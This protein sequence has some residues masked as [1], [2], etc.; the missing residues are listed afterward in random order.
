MRMRKVQMPKLFKMLLRFSTNEVLPR[1]VLQTTPQIHLPIAQRIKQ[2]SQLVP[3]SGI[4]LV[5]IR[6]DV[7]TGIY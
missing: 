3:V 5:K 6:P 4:K 7:L 2:M 1:R